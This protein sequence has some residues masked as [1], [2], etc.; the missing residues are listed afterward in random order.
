MNPISTARNEVLEAIETVATYT[1]DGW[2]DQ[3]NTPC[4]VI[5]PDEPYVTLGARYGEKE[6]NIRVF[7]IVKNTA[8]LAKAN[9][10]LDEL[11]DST[12]DKL[13]E[14]EYATGNVDQPE[15]F[16]IGNTNYLG[17]S[18]QITIERGPQMN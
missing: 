11:I 5:A 6:I 1:Y 10:D 17:T 3:I 14:E 8:S 2:T 7:M 18:L 16:T 9:A 15:T 4:L 12:L 13:L